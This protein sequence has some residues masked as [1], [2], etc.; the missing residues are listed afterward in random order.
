[1]IE[2]KSIEF[3]RKKKKSNHVDKIV[4]DLFGQIQSTFN[5]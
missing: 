3:L 2:L 5:K 4:I 1:M